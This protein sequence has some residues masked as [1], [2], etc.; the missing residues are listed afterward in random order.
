MGDW[1]VV[2]R[3]DDGCTSSEADALRIMRTIEVDAK[4]D[5]AAGASQWGACSQSPYLPYLAP[6]SDTISA[7]LSNIATQSTPPRCSF[8]IHDMLTLFPQHQRK[9]LD[10]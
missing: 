5:A 7:D 6:P 9:S 1:Q 3:S 8:N 2:K 10:L 4:G